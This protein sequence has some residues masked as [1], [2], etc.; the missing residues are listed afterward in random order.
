MEDGT[1]DFCN[2][3]Y[4]CDYY[5]LGCLGERESWLLDNV[6]NMQILGT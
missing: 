2:K 5:Q 4:I 1:L 6:A 3:N